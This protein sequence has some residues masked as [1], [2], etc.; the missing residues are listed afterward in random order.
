MNFIKQNQKIFFVGKI[1]TFFT[2]WGVSNF[3]KGKYLDEDLG[4][5]FEKISLHALYKSLCAGTSVGEL[6]FLV[7]EMYKFLE[8]PYPVVDKIRKICIAMIGEWKETLRDMI[9]DGVSL[10]LWKEILYWDR[11]LKLFKAF[12]NYTHN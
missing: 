6:K 3:L 7:R 11:R 2:C 12:D 9:N 1:E 5:N 8:L 10:Q 4:G